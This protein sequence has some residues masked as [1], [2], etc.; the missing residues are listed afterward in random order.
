MMLLM[1]T[2]NFQN[3]WNVLKTVIIQNEIKN[4]S[5]KTMVAIAWP[6]QSAV[7]II[8]EI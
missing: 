7:L 8:P 5:K 4:S 6:E 2:D 1:A 3:I